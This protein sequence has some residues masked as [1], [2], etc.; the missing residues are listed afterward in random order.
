M[1]TAELQR[2]LPRSLAAAVAA[3]SATTLIL[4]SLI[5]S[6]GQAVRAEESS[7]L[8]ARSME[9][10]IVAVGDSYLAGIGAGEYLTVDGC[11]RS[12][13]SPA[14]ALAARTRA[15][16][17]DLTC[18]GNT[19]PQALRSTSRIPANAD[20][21]LIQAGGND[22]GFAILAGACLLGGSSTCSAAVGAAHRQLPEV[23]RGTIDLVRQARLKAPTSEVIVLGY[24]RLLG[25]AKQC[26]ALLDQNRVRDVNRLQRT[27]DRVIKSAARSAGAEFVDWPRS[28]DR[29][30]LCSGDPWYALPG[31]RID[32]LLHPDAR[33]TI[34]LSRSLAKA[35][36]P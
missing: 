20:L 17:V 5:L 14:A 3:F 22:I 29:A 24:P 6:S 30:S 27:L 23:R 10:T 19:I 21:T 34:A 9:P 16:L 33:A 18:P 8:T 11:R 15:D 32:D 36:T 4:S 26:S 13:R 7:G 2:R 12:A 31:D 35:W 1:R 25:G 28:V